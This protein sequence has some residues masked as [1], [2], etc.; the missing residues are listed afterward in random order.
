MTTKPTEKTGSTSTESVAADIGYADAMAELDQILSELDDDTIDIDVLSDRVERA[1]ELI[2]IC[3]GR[4]G[5]AQQQV[6]A[7]VETLDQPEAGLDSP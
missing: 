6:A 7:I 4:I 3:R 5:S 2:A 1:A